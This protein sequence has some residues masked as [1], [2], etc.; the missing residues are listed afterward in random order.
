MPLQVQLLPTSSGDHTQAQPLTTFMVNGTIAVDAGSLGFALTGEQ[1]AQVEHVVLTHA[2][3]DHTASLPIAIDAAFKFLKRPMRIY[4]A[5][6]TVAA[7]RNHLFND[8]VWIDFSKFKVTGTD[9]PC[10]E[11]VEM[12]PRK[13]IT[14]DGVRLTSIPVNHPVPTVGIIAQSDSASVVFTSD[15]WKTDE[16]WAEA[17]KLPDLKAVFV[18]CSFPDELEKLAKDSGHLTPRLVAEET[19]KLGRRVPIYCVHL[20]PS[21]REI[22]QKQLEPYA[23]RGIVQAEIGKVYSW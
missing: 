20:K 18:E 17:A 19:A 2:H 14:L 12:A 16:I 5:A 22:L 15:T 11:W 13:T 7:V 6:P 9:Q 21:M 4:A 3:M 10:M 23:E 8:E 1:L